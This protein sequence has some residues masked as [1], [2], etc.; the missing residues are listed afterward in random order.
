[1]LIQTFKKHNIDSLNYSV[2]IIS[3]G[4]SENAGETDKWIEQQGSK[5]EKIVA[6]KDNIFSNNMVESCNNFF[7]N[8]FMIDKVARTKAELSNH[9]D[10]YVP[11]HNLEWFPLE[12]Y[13]LNPLE[14]LRGE[15]PDKHRFSEQLI[16][17]KKNRLIENQNFDSQFCKMCK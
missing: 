6:K 4:G 16:Q 9:I 1:M 8:G 14:V 2:H 17:A 15:I 7:K 5:V 11:S 13:G 12:F 3:D 10:N